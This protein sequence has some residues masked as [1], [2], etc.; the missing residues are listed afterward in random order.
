MF[1][2]NVEP[3]LIYIGSSAVIA[4]GSDDVFLSDSI[5][6]MTDVSSVIETDAARQP[7]VDK[8]TSLETVTVPQSP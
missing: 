2:E 3:D 8:D 4:T 1:S 5:T 6:S 7:E